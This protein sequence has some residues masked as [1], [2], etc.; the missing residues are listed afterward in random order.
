[1]VVSS[2]VASIL[3][4]I[5]AFDFGQVQPV[6]GFE[7]YEQGEGVV[8]LGTVENGKVKVYLDLYWEAPVNNP[9]KEIGYI[10]LGYKG[11]KSFDSGILYC[12][13]V[14]VMMMKT[15]SPHDFHPLLSLGT[16]YAVVTNLLDTDKFYAVVSV[17][18]S[19][20]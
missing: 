10:L 17:R 14:P 9:D 12:P 3:S 7:P 6:D 11:K 13:Y 20:L 16:R 2:Q 8:Y 4:A 5:K 15:I 18:N 19:A 1:M